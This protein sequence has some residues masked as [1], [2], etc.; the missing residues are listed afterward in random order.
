VENLAT[1]RRVDFH[2]LYLFFPLEGLRVYQENQENL[3]RMIRLADEFF[4]T[5]NDPAQITVTEETMALLRKVDPATMSE[6]G[7]EK[8]PIAWVLVIPTTHALMTQ[9]IAKQI[10]EQDL[11]AKTPLGVKFDAVYLCSALVLPEFRG[12][13]LAK[14]L[15]T[16]AVNSII[17]RH[18]IK[19][20]FYWGF[21]LEGEKL[22]SSIAREL[23]LPLAKRPD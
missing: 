11:L 23:G 18:P 14:Q 6:I 12:K 21:S 2:R 20:L 17:T 15:A 3:E 16:S 1:F 8:G 9:F 22:A 19:H 13:G 4:E 7:S 10:N 5:K